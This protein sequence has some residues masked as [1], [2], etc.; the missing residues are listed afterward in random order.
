MTNDNG[1]E[2]RKDHMAYTERVGI[3]TRVV[4]T[5]SPWQNGMVERHG[6]VSGDIFKAIAEE[7][8]IE[9]VEEVKLAL[10]A[11]N[12]CKNRRP[13]PSGF[14]KSAGVWIRREAT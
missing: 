11:V 7:C 10:A 9:G 1:S 6:G 14:T 3:E 13:D 5:E 8:N 4:P 2:F 12:T